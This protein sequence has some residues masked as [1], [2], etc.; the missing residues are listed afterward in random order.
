[1]ATR[2]STPDQ[3]E[4]SIWFSGTKF[5]LENEPLNGEP[6]PV[7]ELPEVLPNV[8]VQ[9]TVMPSSSDPTIWSQCALR[10]SRWRIL[11]NVVRRIVGPFSHRLDKARQRLG[12]SLAPR[13]AITSVKESERLL[14][15]SSQRDSFPTL[16]DADGKVKDSSLKNITESH[17]L[18]GLV[19]LSSR[20]VL[21]V[22]GRLRNAACPFEEKHPLI[23]HSNSPITKLFAEHIHRRS[24]H[25]GKLITSNKIREAGVF[26]VGGRRLV[27][28][29]LKECLTCKLLRG[30]EA[31][32]LMSD[33]PPERLSDVAPF[34]H[35]GLDVFGPYHV[36]QGKTTRRTTGTAKQFVLLIN[37][38]SSRAIHLEPLECMDTTAVMNAIRR[39]VAIR[40][41]CRTV[42]SDHGS[43]FMGAI[44]QTDQFQR[45]Q[46]DLEAGGIVWR[47]NPVGASHY[48]VR[49]KDW[50][51]EESVGSISHH[52]PD[53]TDP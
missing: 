9:R 44:G 51:C 28:A 8:Q 50:E 41:P 23:L 25:Q 39:F 34:D 19:P 45:L 49:T 13:S 42:F 24:P 30:V 5:L 7:N 12:V 27:E 2:P 29:I 53:Y 1:M 40:G 4:E 11:V 26:V 37:C 32:Q 6:G 10:V 16:F 3:I 43:N 48:G 52:P 31:S 33:L 38:L 20:G 22:G 35:V 36:K 15:Q 14:F 46:E 18:R 21:R 17:P 47:L